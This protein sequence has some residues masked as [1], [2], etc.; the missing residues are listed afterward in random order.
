MKVMKKSVLSVFLMLIL[1]FALSAQS[2]KKVLTLEDYPQWK[3]IRSPS[4]S[5]N[6]IWVCYTLRPNGGDS[7]VTIKS[8]S[9]DKIYEIP[10]AS[11]AR[12]SEDSRWAAYL[13]GVSKAETKKL[14][15]A[16][17]PVPTKG[18][19][20]NLTTGEKHT[21][22]NTSAINFSKNSKFFAAKKAKQD[23]AA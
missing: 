13:I 12:F 10:Y 6:G 23:K 1:A 21:I 15:K 14:Q 5:S 4:I 19:L 8:L 22:E 9:T 20:L 7:T 11:G 2:E 3:H 16:K 18:E 17:K